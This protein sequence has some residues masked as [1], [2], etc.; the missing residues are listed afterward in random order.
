MTCLGSDCCFGGLCGGGV[1]SSSA[2]WYLALIS[3]PFCVLTS[4][5]KNF[6]LREKGKLIFDKDSNCNVTVSY[7]EAGT[8]CELTVYVGWGRGYKCFVSRCRILS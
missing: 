1:R 6:F 7:Y 3:F 5:K 4:I 8:K 2:Q